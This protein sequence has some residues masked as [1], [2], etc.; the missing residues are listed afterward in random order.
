MSQK[1][2]VHST[3]ADNLIW[4]PALILGDSQPTSNFSLGESGVSFRVSGPIFW[5]LQASIPCTHTHFIDI[6]T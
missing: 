3:L 6:Y 2:R 1:L 5:P 4:F